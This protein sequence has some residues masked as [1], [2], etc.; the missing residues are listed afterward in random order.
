MTD[1]VAILISV[2]DAIAAKAAREPHIECCGLLGGMSDESLPVITEIYP[3]TNLLASTRAYEI[4]PEELFRIMRQM[5]ADGLR[6]MGIYHSHPTG[7]NHPSSTDIARAFYPDAVH[8]IASPIR[9]IAAPIRAFRIRNAI[10][11]EL[12]IKLVPIS[13]HANVPS[14]TGQRHLCEA[15][16]MR[17]S[18]LLSGGKA[19]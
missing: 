13:S 5:R 1:S 6:F 9:N 8:F 19:R 7:E 10:A 17:S 12:R 3:A 15:D 4:A 14:V 18:G 11:S 2:V 16:L